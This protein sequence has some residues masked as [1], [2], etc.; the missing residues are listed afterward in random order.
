MSDGE[1]S[2]EMKLNSSDIHSDL[3]SSSQSISKEDTNDHFQEGVLSLCNEMGS[4]EGN[5]QTAIFL[6]LCKI[7][8]EESLGDAEYRQLS[9]EAIGF[10]KELLKRKFFFD[11]N[12]MNFELIKCRRRNEEQF[13][14]VV[15]KAFKRLFRNFKR[16]NNGFIKGSKIYDEL[17]FYQFYFKETAAVDHAQL[18]WYLLPGSKIQKEFLKN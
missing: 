13:K 2:S 1:E 15:K 7:F 18:E 9:Q 6:V 17:E 5:L 12:F 11:L 10:I 8:K 16:A 4:P 3:D 14:F